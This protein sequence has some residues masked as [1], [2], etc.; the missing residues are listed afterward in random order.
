MLEFSFLVSSELATFLSNANSRLEDSMYWAPL[1][2]P[3]RHCSQPNEGYGLHVRVKG[4]KGAAE[5]RMNSGL[6]GSILPGASLV[7]QMVKD[8]PAMCRPWFN[9]RVRKIPWRREWQPTP[10]LLPGEFH[11]QRSL[12]GYSPWDCKE[13]DKTE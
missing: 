8:L 10:V 1:H 5:M 6:L 12:V 7:V 11:G 2:M 3:Q 13:S 4:N 9:P